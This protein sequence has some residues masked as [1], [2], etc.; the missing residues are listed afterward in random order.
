VAAPSATPR[1]DPS[2]IKLKDGYST[3]IT[4]ARDTDVGL[5]EKTVTPPGLDGGDSIEQTTMHNDDWR[6]FAPRSLVTLTEMSFVAA[7]DPNVYTSVLAL[8]NVEDTITVTFPDGSTLAFYGYLKMFEPSELTEG[9]QPEATVT[10]VPTNWDPAGDV[11]AA[12]VMT[13]VAG[14]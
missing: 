2:G 13:S 1:V 5:W 3:L 8:V 10:I 7:Y 4:F 12:P 9:E 14:T 6:T 11:E